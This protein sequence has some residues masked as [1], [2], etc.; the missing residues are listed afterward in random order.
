MFKPIHVAVVDDSAFYR[1]FIRTQLSQISNYRIAVEATQGLDL[2]SQLSVLH[3]IPEICILD[4]KMPIMDGF[5]TI[6]ILRKKYPR[7]KILVL[8]T[9]NH[10]YTV[11]NMIKYGANGF[12]TKEGGLHTLEAALNDIIETGFHYSHNADKDMFDR[13]NKN[14]DDVPMLTKVERKILSYFFAY[15]H[16]KEIAEELSI[17]CHTV[18]KHVQNIYR[19]T[20]VNS[21]QSLVVFAIKNDLVN[22]GD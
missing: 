19:K 5:E 16:C 15:G 18:E 22:F 4:V 7:I 11:A 3:P 2:F 9:C 6:K 20:G 21:R 8:T 17:S 12:L 10:I 1:Y 14:S 13:I